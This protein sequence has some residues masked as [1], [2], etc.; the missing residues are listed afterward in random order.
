MVEKESFNKKI[1]DLSQQYNI[2]YALVYRIISSYITNCKAL[3][4]SGYIVQIFGMITVVPS[5]VVSDEVH[6]LAYQCRQI[7]KEQSYPYITTITLIRGYL[8]GIRNDLFAGR[9]SGIKGFIQL[10]PLLHSDGSVT[11]YGSTAAALKTYL[12]SVRGQEFSARA[13]TFKFLRSEVANQLNGGDLI[14]RQ[15]A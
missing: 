6:T 5:E 1:F 4:V 10:K 11:L 9:P 12:K 13:F 3:L 8:D 14:D 2:P 7:S 15:D